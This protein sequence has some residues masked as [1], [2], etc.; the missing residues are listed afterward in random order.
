[1]QTVSI[2]VLFLAITIKSS[3][4]SFFE[5]NFLYHFYGQHLNRFAYQEAHW[6]HYM[7]RIRNQ[8]ALYNEIFNV[9]KGIPDMACIVEWNGN[10]ASRVYIP[11][12]TEYE[13]M[14]II[15]NEI[16]AVKNSENIIT[17][18]H[19]LRLKTI[20][21]SYKD[22][23][24][25]LDEKTT[26]YKALQLYFSQEWEEPKGDDQK[27][28][29]DVKR[30]Y[31]FPEIRGEFSHFKLLQMKIYKWDISPKSHGEVYNVVNEKWETIKE[32][33]EVINLNPKQSILFL[34]NAEKYTCKG[35]NKEKD[36]QTIATIDPEKK[37][38]NIDSQ[39]FN[40]Y[41][42]EIVNKT[43]N[44]ALDKVIVITS[45]FKSKAPD[46]LIRMRLG[47]ALQ[48]FLKYKTNEEDT[49]ILTGDLNSEI[50]EVATIIN[51]PIRR[52]YDNKDVDFLPNPC[53]NAMLTFK[54]CKSGN[55]KLDELVD[56]LAVAN[57]KL[58]NLKD[59]F[60]FTISKFFEQ[61]YIDLEEKIKTIEKNISDLLSNGSIKKEYEYRLWYETSS[62]PTESKSRIKETDYFNQELFILEL[63]NKIQNTQLKAIHTDFMR[64][65]THED[66][67]QKKILEEYK[68]PQS[69][70]FK[71][72]ERNPKLFVTFEEL[73]QK[74]K[75][76][77]TRKRLIS[78]TIMEGIF[79]D[80]LQVLMK[81]K[82]DIVD[83]Y[84]DMT[85]YTDV[86][87]RKYFDELSKN[88]QF[89]ENKKNSFFEEEKYIQISEMINNAN[90]I[91][92]NPEK[93][94]FILVRPAKSLKVNYLGNLI[95]TPEEFIKKGVNNGFFS[96]DHLPSYDLIKF[97]KAKET[98]N[99]ANSSL[100]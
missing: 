8:I 79:V 75:D 92:L 50:D 64:K 78:R 86:N 18:E 76:D 61:K 66:H 19:F 65:L 84:M 11:T 33:S 4:I 41:I 49:I 40:V 58:V 29:E 98:S 15:I 26:K 54:K 63:S 96:S 7:F 45:H 85:Q 73:N 46:H 22:G 44:D 3:Q 51:A 83:T 74:L 23:Y 31:N 17:E 88:I 6:H 2:Y 67:F 55:T 57:N 1:M 14:T 48:D 69:E 81:L 38:P 37:Y 13:E 39:N 9:D 90:A 97:I 47:K 60:L 56:E 25:P 52:E 68:N 87:S 21:K 36:R 24:F 43:E 93:I 35:P 100:I 12:S 53:F 30:W 89:L 5:H 80:Y 99:P 16:F 34:V 10:S 59:K 72:F 94:D 62:H 42:C 91:F 71:N 77:L 20:F 82:R 95:F 32:Q 70:V 27:D 28:Y